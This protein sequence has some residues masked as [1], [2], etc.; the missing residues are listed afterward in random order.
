MKYFTLV[1]IITGF[2]YFSFMLLKIKLIFISMFISVVSLNN[3][4]TIGYVTP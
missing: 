2:W 1:E 3:L 4:M